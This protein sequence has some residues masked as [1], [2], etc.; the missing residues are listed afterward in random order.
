MKK[1]IIASLLSIVTFT[2]F[3]GFDF[4]DPFKTENWF[5][6]SDTVTLLP[7]QKD[8]IKNNELYVLNYSKKKYIFIYAQMTMGALTGSGLSLCFHSVLEQAKG[9]PN[10]LLRN[11]S[12]GLLLVCLGF[13]GNHKLEKTQRLVRIDDLHTF[14]TTLWNQKMEDLTIRATG[15]EIRKEL[16]NTVKIL[17]SIIENDETLVEKFGK[18]LSEQK[19]NAQQNK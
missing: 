11:A 17:Y 12:I 5:D 19:N 2:A 14:N 7:Y 1:N 10:N 6:S 16:M 15:Q 18:I 9:L 3:C 13:M 8:G 4:S